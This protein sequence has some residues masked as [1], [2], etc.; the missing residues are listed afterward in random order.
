MFCSKVLS[1]ISL[2]VAASAVSGMFHL[3]LQMIKKVP[4]KEDN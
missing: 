4:R 3:S 2:A 1:I